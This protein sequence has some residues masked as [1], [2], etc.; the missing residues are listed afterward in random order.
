MYKT[1]VYTNRA[2]RLRSINISIISPFF[3]PAFSPPLFPF[4]L[5]SPFF[6]LFFFFPATVPERKEETLREKPGNFFF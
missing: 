2:Y 4:L 1:R 3:A 6:F 5:L